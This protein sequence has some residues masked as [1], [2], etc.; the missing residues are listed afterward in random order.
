[1]IDAIF[2]LDV[3][4]NFITTYFNEKTGSEVLDQKEIAIKY[5]KGSFLLDIA[6]VIPLDL[7]FEKVLG[8]N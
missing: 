2:I 7:I 1:M 8:K 4:L 5:L 3:F 6:A